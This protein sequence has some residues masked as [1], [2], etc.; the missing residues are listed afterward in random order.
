MANRNHTVTIIVTHEKDPSTDLLFVDHH[1]IHRKNW[2]WIHLR[3]QL[4]WQQGTAEGY[5]AGHVGFHVYNKEGAGSMQFGSLREPVLLDY[6][7]PTYSCDLSSNA[8]AYVVKNGPAYTLKWDTNSSEWKNATWAKDILTFSYWI[9]KDGKVGDQQLWQIAVVFN[10]TKT[11]NSWNVLPRGPGNTGGFS[12]NI[13]AN[14][15]F[16]FNCNPGNFPPPDNCSSIGDGIKTVFPYQ[17]AFQFDQL[18][19]DI[20][21]GAM[22]CTKYSD[23]GDVYA[24]QGRSQNIHIVGTYSLISEKGEQLGELSTH[25]QKL[26]VANKAIPKSGVSGDRLWWDGLSPDETKQTSLPTSG[27]VEFSSGGHVIKSS[28]FGARGIRQL[29]AST[30]AV[31]P[32]LQLQDLLNMN[33]Y[34][35]DG[36]GN[37]TDKVQQN[38]MDDFYKI[39]Q[40]YMPSD[41]LHNFIAP[42]PPDIGDLRDI[43][44]DDK[45]RNSQWYG[46]LA[47]PYL[48]QALAQNKTDTVAKLNARRAQAVLKESTSTSEVY[49]T[50]L[51][52]CIRTSGRRSFLL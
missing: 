32:S 34:E 8:G 19:I 1:H 26:F 49:K 14:D 11:H 4:V 37:M 41:Y 31:Q 20:T 17:M 2:Q 44:E 43:A 25:G 22:L 38:S 13:N 15:L 12:S 48:V 45:T 29:A 52:N 35:M 3:S 10:D 40:Y 7:H 16:T 27:F 9:E 50:K 42:N 46:N 33:P 6:L 28:S 39:L 24:M 5:L 47:V 18:A 30:I 23:Q 36:Q 51:P 21:G